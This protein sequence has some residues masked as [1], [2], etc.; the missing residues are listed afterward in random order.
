M[1]LTFEFVNHS[2]VLVSEGVTPAHLSSDER[3]LQRFLGKDW[4]WELGQPTIVT[5]IITQ[6]LFTNGVVMLATSGRLA[7]TDNSQP[8][9][10]LSKAKD[11]IQKFIKLNGSIQWKALGINFAAVLPLDDPQG[12]FTKACLNTKFGES[13]P[14]ATLQSIATVSN[15]K[16]A[17]RTITLQVAEQ[18]M[19]EDGQPNGS[20]AV[21]AVGVNYHIDVSETNDNSLRLL[22]R[23]AQ[24]RYHDSAKVLQTIAGRFGANG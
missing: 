5:P 4:G 12:A 16:D 24:Q 1:T 15:L 14:G 7:L 3:F 2:F 10:E 11:A 22:V 21:V 19:I 13:L 9:P 8:D 23:N 17:T 18:T 6:L 20:R